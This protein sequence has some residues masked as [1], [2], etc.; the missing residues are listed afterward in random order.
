MMIAKVIFNEFKNSLK[1]EPGRFALT[2]RIAVLCALMAGFAMLYHIPESAISC[3]LIIFLMKP[4]ATLNMALSIALALIICVVVFILFVITDLTINSSLLRMM[5][6][7]I[8][9]YLFVYL[10]ARFKTELG[11]LIALILAFLLSVINF[12]PTGEIATRA[13]LY[14]TL[15]A[16]SPLFLMFLFNLFLGKRSQTLIIEKLHLRFTKMINY[17]SEPA[18][19]N[20]KDFQAFIDKS[21]SDCLLH[22]KLIHLFRLMPILQTNWIENAVNQ[23]FKLLNLL[24]LTHGFISEDEK[25]IILENCQK[26]KAGLKHSNFEKNHFIPLQPMNPLSENMLANTIIKTQQQLIQ[27]DFIA[28]PKPSFFEKWQHLKTKLASQKS[29]KIKTAPFHYFAIKVT[30]SAVICYCIYN[31]LDWTGIHTAMITCY[32]VALS[33]TAETVHKLILRICGCLLGAFIGVISIVYILPNLDEVGGLMVLIFL[34]MLIPAWITA[35]TALF[36]YAGVQIGLAFLLTTV[37]GFGPTVDLA[38]AQ[39]RILGILLGNVV[40]YLFFTFLWPVSLSQTIETK[41]IQW[42]NLQSSNLKTTSKMP[43]NIENVS[44]LR[45]QSTQINQ[46]LKLVIFEQDKSKLDAEDHQLLSHILIN[47]NQLNALCLLPLSTS[48]IDQYQRELNHYIKIRSDLE[49]KPFIIQLMH[50]TSSSL[51]L[52]QNELR[53]KHD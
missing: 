45:E 2:W 24:S 47:F 37:H 13:L 28:L 42:L 43:L 34:G 7:F 16:V 53:K 6:I 27:P 50:F 11:N 32:V 40:S 44:T 15:M 4:D 10:G 5:A 21:S 36:S 19:I 38:V 35:G 29:P 46:S 23:S 41:F 31:I 8:C 25:A 20:K 14:A 52:F 39:D 18:L 12:A 26:L 9:S 51:T 49:F 48:L 1:P 22:L 3:Y 33:T 30:C 17:L